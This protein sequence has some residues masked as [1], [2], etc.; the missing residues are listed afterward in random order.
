MKV[1][2]V[3]TTAPSPAI[4]RKLAKELVRLRLAACVTIREGFQSVYTWKGRIQS[5]KEVLML[6]KTRSGAVKRLEKA[7]KARHPYE[8][9]EF[10]VLPVKA[11]S[12][13]YLKWV[14]KSCR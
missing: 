4:A 8:V 1:V 3:L 10:L 2:V 11:G 5:E 13:D 12:K 7:I 9:P 6:V 14:I